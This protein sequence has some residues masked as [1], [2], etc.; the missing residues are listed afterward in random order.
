[1]PDG[2]LQMLTL[3]LETGRKYQTC[4]NDQ[5]NKHS[6]SLRRKGQPVQRTPK[7]LKSTCTSSGWGDGTD[8]CRESIR[9]QSESLTG[10]L[11]GQPTFIQLSGLDAGRKLKSE[12]LNAAGKSRKEKEDLRP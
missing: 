10:A 6:N 8:D 11:P 9:R 12:N 3:H 7:L 5:K 4:C 1:M 2:C